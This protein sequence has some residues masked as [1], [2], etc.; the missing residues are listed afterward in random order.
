MIAQHA[1][2]A[3]AVG[4]TLQAPAGIQMSGVRGK[5]FTHRGEPLVGRTHGLMELALADHRMAVDGDLAA[6]RGNGFVSMSEALL[7]EG[8]ATGPALDAVFLAYRSPDLITHDVAGCYLAERLPGTPVPLAVAD[9]GVG[10]PFTALRIAASMARS[11]ELTQ[12]A[13]FVFDQN[14]TGWH[15]PFG[16]DTPVDTDAAVLLTFEAGDAGV[17]NIT[18]RRTEDPANALGEL[19]G[20]HPAVPVLAGAGLRAHVPDADGPPAGAGRDCTSVWF[21]LADRSPLRQ[22][23]LLADYDRVTGRLHS[24]L[25][26]PSPGRVA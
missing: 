26:A 25:V 13:L 15:E 7:A 5:V 23:V 24:C 14:S 21:A 6:R 1:S 20:D 18:E 10:A 3:T 22:P 17:R 4:D 12:G 9:Q 8:E 11:G 16:R 19:R 2:R